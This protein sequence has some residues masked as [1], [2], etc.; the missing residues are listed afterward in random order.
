MCVSER[1]CLGLS[2]TSNIINVI[3]FHIFYYKLYT[4]YAYIKTYI[5]QNLSYM[6]FQ[7]KNACFYVMNMM[8]LSNCMSS[9]S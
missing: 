4:L 5:I 3:K 6:C 8:M 2:E 9:H 1:F 7:K